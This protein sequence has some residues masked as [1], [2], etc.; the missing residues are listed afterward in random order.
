MSSSLDH[1]KRRILQVLESSADAAS[2]TALAR[3]LRDDGVSQRD[4]YR[5][6]SDQLILADGDDPRYDAIADTLDLIQSGPWSKG[7]AF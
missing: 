5:L 6:F 2:V 7:N 4:L 1:A 3:E